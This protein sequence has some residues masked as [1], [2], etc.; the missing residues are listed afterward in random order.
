MNADA[1]QSL[2]D[3]LRLDSAALAARLGG[4][5]EHYERLRTRARLPF[6]VWD[7]LQRLAGRE[8]YAWDAEARCW[9]MKRAQPV[10]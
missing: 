3:A 2:M 7:A 1:L 5:K 6:P 8:G 9:R 10:P 4:R